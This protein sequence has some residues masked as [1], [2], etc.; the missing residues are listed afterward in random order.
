MDVVDALAVAL[1]HAKRVAAGEGDV[2]GIEEQPHRLAGK[3][4]QPVDVVFRLDRRRHVMVEGE[5][6]LLLVAMLGEGGQLS[7]V[8]AHLLVVEPRAL[9][10]RHV[11]WFCTVPVV[12][13]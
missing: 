5:R 1:R 8:G 4:H 11:R 7:P 13:P 6:H 2:A 10:E 9:G 12:S 3:I